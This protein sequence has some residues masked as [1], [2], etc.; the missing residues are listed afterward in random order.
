[1][2]TRR[3]QIRIAA[4]QNQSITKVLLGVVKHPE[5]NV[6]VCSLFF[7][8][9]ED[10]SSRIGAGW[11]HV[12]CLLCLKPTKNH[13]HERQRREREQVRLLVRQVIACRPWP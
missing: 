12:L 6:H 11:H 7:L 10:P 9:H 5:N 8:R 1:M 13:I 4:D 2:R 3:H